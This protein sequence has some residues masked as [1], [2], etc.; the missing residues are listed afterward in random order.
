LDLERLETRALLDVGDTLGTALPTGLAL[1]GQFAQPSEPVG[2]DPFTTRD[3]DLYRL[4]ASAGARLVAETSRPANGFPVDT[5]LRLFDAGGVELAFDDN[6]ALN[7][8]SRLEFTFTA[9]G[10][11][12]LG[13]SGSP[14]R[15][16]DA[17]RGGSGASGSVGTYRLDVLVV[18]TTDEDSEDDVNGADVIPA[19]GRL[20]GTTG[21][22]PAAGRLLSPGNGPGGLTAPAPGAGVGAPAAAGR[23]TAPAGGFRVGPGGGENPNRNG[24][25]NAPVPPPGEGRVT[26]LLRESEMR[27]LAQTLR[28]NFLT[29]TA[30]AGTG[31]ELPAEL[32]T[33]EAGESSALRLTFTIDTS[34][35][36]PLLRLALAR[37]RPVADLLPL[38][39]S[40]P[41]LAA[42]LMTGGVDLEAERAAD[43]AAPG[44]AEKEATGSNG[45][46]PRNAAPRALSIDEAALLEFLTGLDDKSLR[47][48]P[49]TREELLGLTPVEVPIS[50]AEEDDDPGAAAAGTLPDPLRPG[51]AGGSTR[52]LSD[53]GVSL[54]FLLGLFQPGGRAEQVADQ[55]IRPESQAPRWFRCA[56]IIP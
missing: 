51:S 42:T 1:A 35:R 48:R 24:S 30:L 50:E 19:P 16:Y 5:F 37:R 40:T 26:L 44:G 41:A 56:T 9:D 34:L 39:E 33:E 6:S 2:D 3:V 23:P 18:Q 31:E 36:N 32:V 43:A 10:T 12:Y 20:V 27:P 53:A 46:T 22:A 38:N 54:L 28:S 25:R 17:T 52:P 7:G 47:R 15:F 55:R 8:Y 45:A 11:Y 4:P 21:A 49:R 13:V 29:A 14:N